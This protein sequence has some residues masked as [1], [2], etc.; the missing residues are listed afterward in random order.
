MQTKTVLTASGV[1]LAALQVIDIL[2][3][4][5]AL[6]GQPTATEGNPLAAQVVDL[7]TPVLICIK[8]VAALLVWAF[9]NK[10]Y[11]KTQDKWVILPM[12][13]VTI[14]YVVIC[15]NNIAAATA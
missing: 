11:N 6:S 9:V 7:P 10:V 2:T 8:L 4:K 12:L 13:A 3:T 1:T 14:I 15:A 5:S